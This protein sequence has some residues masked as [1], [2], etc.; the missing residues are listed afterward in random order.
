VQKKQPPKFIAWQI[1][2]QQLGDDYG[3]VKDFKKKASAALRK[4]A[5]LYPGLTIAKAKGGFT[6]HATRLA[7]PQKPLQIS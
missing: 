7:V 6:I 2:M 3:T 4:I 5:T 1:L